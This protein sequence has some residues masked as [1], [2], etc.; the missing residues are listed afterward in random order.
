MRTATADELTVRVGELLRERLEA[1]EGFFGLE[2]ERLARCC[3][4]MA[5]RF[6]REG[7][8]VALGFRLRFDDSVVEVDIAAGDAHLGPRGDAIHLPVRRAP[9]MVEVEVP[10]ARAPQ[11]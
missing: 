3:H 10:E 5:E 6:A 7:R 8:L 1:G 9:G 11:T 4:A 2:A